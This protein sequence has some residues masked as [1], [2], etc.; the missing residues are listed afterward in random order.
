MQQADKQERNRIWQLRAAVRDRAAL[1]VLV[2][3]SVLACLL[4][5]CQPAA[6]RPEPKA[7]PEEAEAPPPAPAQEPPPAP[8][9]PPASPTSTALAEPATSTA[10]AEPA[11]SVAAAEAVTAAVA[12]PG[13]ATPT[14]WE[15]EVSDTPSAEPEPKQLASYDRKGPATAP[16]QVAVHTDRNAAEFPG[17]VTSARISYV[18]EAVAVAGK[19]ARAMKV[20]FRLDNQIKPFAGC[21][22]KAG[23]SANACGCDKIVPYA[24]IALVHKLRRNLQLD[25][26]K[27]LS[28]WAKSADP[29]DLHV[30]LGC[31]VEPRPGAGYL[32]AARR[33]PD[34]CWHAIRSELKL[35]KPIAIA[36]GSTWRRYQFRLDALPPSEVVVGTACTLSTVTQISYVIKK[37]GSLKAGEYPK[38]KGEILFDD[39]EA[40][41]TVGKP[42]E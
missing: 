14:K 5:G 40:L 20:V 39:L 15:V 21:D 19:L 6:D 22:G 2:L 23:A 29:F 8:L 7:E 27:Y 17:S 9:P 26:S 34:P 11:T 37:D 28:F 4:I 42:P 38:D 3:L 30:S 24:Y 18:A 1:W 33:H 12:A 32:D 36:G 10:L 31:Y 35:P 25:T 13:A 41:G 16:W